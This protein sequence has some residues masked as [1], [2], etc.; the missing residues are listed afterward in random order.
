MID[1]VASQQQL[2]ILDAQL[3]QDPF[4][5]TTT[6]VPVVPC[7]NHHGEN[8]LLSRRTGRSFCLGS[9]GLFLFQIHGFTIGRLQRGRLCG[10]ILILT[11]V[12]V[13]VVIT[14]VSA[15]SSCKTPFVISLRFS[16]IHGD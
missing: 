5:A 1:D 15:S 11:M 7:G 12:V 14:I 8:R 10:A 2:F 9:Y 6:A 13:V 3:D 4:L 16:T